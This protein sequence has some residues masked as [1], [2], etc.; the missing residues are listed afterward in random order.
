[1][2]AR[3]TRAGGRYVAGLRGMYE[4]EEPVAQESAQPDSPVGPAVEKLWLAARMDP[5]TVAWLAR[6]ASGAALREIERV[7]DAGNHRAG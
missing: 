5:L 1:M 2:H 6:M 4:V 7:A 3:D